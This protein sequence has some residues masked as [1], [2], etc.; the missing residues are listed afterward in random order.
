M[1]GVTVALALALAFTHTIKTE[2][3]LGRLTQEIHRLDPNA[4]VVDAWRPSW[5]GSGASCLRWNQPGD[6][7]FQALPSCVT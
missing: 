1:V 4:K 6:R 2:R 5:P 7:G 3:Y